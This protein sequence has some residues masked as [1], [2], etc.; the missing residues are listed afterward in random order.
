M[1]G[2]QASSCNVLGSVESLESLLEETFRISEKILSRT[3][4]DIQALDAWN[5]EIEAENL[6]YLNNLSD[7]HKK[8]IVDDRIIN[9]N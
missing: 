1:I 6:N 7:L 2:N 9:L 4:D 3:P 8:F 5:E